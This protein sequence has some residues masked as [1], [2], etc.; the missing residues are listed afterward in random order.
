MDSTGIVFKPSTVI[1]EGIGPFF[2]NRFPVEIVLSTTGHLFHSWTTIALTR[3]LNQFA[4]R[5]SKDKISENV[6]NLFLPWLVSI[7]AQLW[8]SSVVF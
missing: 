3:E 5:L 7:D 4:K 6:E 1:G 8:V 2:D